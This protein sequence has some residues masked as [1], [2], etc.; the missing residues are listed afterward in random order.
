MKYFFALLFVVLLFS[1]YKTYIAPP[2]TFPV[3][4][5]F[6]VTPGE[7]LSTISHQL[8]TDGVIKSSRTFELFMVALGSDKT[9]SEGEY[10]FDGPLSSVGVAMRISGKEFGIQ[11]NKVTFP[12]GFTN[13]EMAD[14]LVKVFPTFNSAQFLAL[15]NNSQGYLFPDTYAFFPSL[16]PDFVIATMKQ[17]YQNKVS[18]LRPD[19]MT[20]GHSESDIIIMASIIEKE[21]QGT[22]DSATIAGILWKRISMGIPLQVD[23][24]PITYSAKGLP[25]APIDNPGLV[26]IEAAVNPTDSPYLY[27]LHDKN[28]VVH[29]ASTFQQH[30]Q[31]IKKYLQ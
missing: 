6:N 16:T 28:G 11:K 24:D 17:N 18:P 19:I 22:T 13:K 21:A 9:V 30:Q 29:Y 31:N 20:S 14:Q 8:V 27:Y 2:S 7:T 23:A 1:A 15:A 3:P 26:A 4:Y 5:D 10:Y 12:E 25:A